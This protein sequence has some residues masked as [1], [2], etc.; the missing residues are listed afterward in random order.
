[1]LT[2]HLGDTKTLFPSIS[3]VT[4]RGDDRLLLLTDGIYRSLDQI[5]VSTLAATEPAASASIRLVSAAGRAGNPDDCAAVLVSAHA[6][7]K[8]LA[9]ERDSSHAPR[10]YASH[11]R[12]A[13]A[14]D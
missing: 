8:E 7:P 13:V 4:V 12:R 14:A 5:S 10:D 11:S 9:T 2:K 6:L 1:M 3:V